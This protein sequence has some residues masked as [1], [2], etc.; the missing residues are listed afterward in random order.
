MA[1]KFFGQYLVEKSVIS[2]ETLLK[3]IALQETVN[4]TIGDIAI[5]MGMMSQSD[6]EQVN[7]AQRNEDLRFADLAVKMGLLTEDALQQALTK[8]SESHIHI[9]KA[10]IMV[11][12]VDA[13]L[14]SGFL[15]EFEE[16]QSQY[17]TDRVVLPPGLKLQ[18]LYE[19][20]ADLSYKMLTR[21]ARLKFRP[22]PCEIVSQIKEAD[23]VAAMDITGDTRCRYIISVSEDVQAQIAKAILAQEKVSQESKEVLDD[24]VMEFVNVICGNIAA[25]SAQLGIALDIMP[26][27]LL[28]SKGGINVPEEFIALDFP[29]CLTNGKASFTI[30][31]Y[32]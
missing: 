30:I 15:E 7:M 9:G 19:M 10:I 32:P 3:S 2:R 17:A 8:Q 23:V 20:M 14:V 27:E 25:K 28:D 13:N 26:P 1:V 4:K 29:I 12:G 5:E 31:I 24:T 6:V 16:E 18:A 22:V 21:V 11:G